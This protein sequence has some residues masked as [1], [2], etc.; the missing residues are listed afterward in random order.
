M[1]NSIQITFFIFFVL[2]GLY[3]FIWG[4]MVLN[5]DEIILDIYSLISILFIRIIQGLDAAELYKVRIQERKNFKLLA[6]YAI[7][8]GIGAFLVVL[9][10]GTQLFAK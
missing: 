9:C 5:S 4:V 6:R 3:S 2:Y 1:E 10:E 8:M 7:I